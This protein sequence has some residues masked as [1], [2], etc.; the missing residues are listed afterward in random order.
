MYINQ[1]CGSCSFHGTRDN[2]LPRRPGFSIFPSFSCKSINLSI[3]LNQSYMSILIFG[4]IIRFILPS[5]FPFK[6]IAIVMKMMI[7]LQRVYFCSLCQCV[8]GNGED[9]EFLSKLQQSFTHIWTKPNETLWTD[10]RAV[11]N[12]HTQ[13]LSSLLL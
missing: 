6:S 11:Y 1:S 7:L 4:F 9:G 10:E 5:F 3:H 2:F 12:L 13:N 8:E